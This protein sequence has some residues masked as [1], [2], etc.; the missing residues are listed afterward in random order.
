MTMINDPEKRFQG[1]PLLVEYIDGI[2]WRLKRNVSYRTSSGE[3]ST[4]RAPFVYD[5]ASIPR[6]LYWLFPPAGDGSNLYGIAA[7][8]HDWL[9]RH[10]K[11]GGRSIT[12][13]EADEL[14][15][16]IMTYIGVKK[17][18]AFTMLA[19]LRLFAFP[20]WRKNAKLNCQCQTPSKN[21]KN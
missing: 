1:L 7:T 11:I 2:K 4:I 17:G 6:F 12:R 13:R 20:M 3:I 15:Y 5:F 8:W 16:E 14:F 9:Y 10:Q 21:D 19:A 18:V